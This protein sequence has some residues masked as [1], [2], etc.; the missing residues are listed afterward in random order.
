MKPIDDDI[1]ERLD[2]LFERTCI[3]EY[4]FEKGTPSEILRMSKKIPVGTWDIG[5]VQLGYF[6][7]MND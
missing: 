5:S 7:D 1:K 2:E 3:T 4:I 6:I